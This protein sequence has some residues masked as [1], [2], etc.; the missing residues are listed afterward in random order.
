MKSILFSINTEFH[1]LVITSLIKQY[2]NDSSKYRVTIL[3]QVNSDGKRFKEQ[4][5]FNLLNANIIML[6]IDNEGV[7]Y[8]T[9]ICAAPEGTKPYIT[10][11]KGAYPSRIRATLINYKFL[12]LQR[13]W[14][15]RIN[16]VSNKN[17]FLKDTDE[18]WISYPEK[19]QNKTHKKVVEINLFSSIEQVEI[20]S[21]IF[22]FNKKKEMPDTEGVIFYLNQWYSE[23]KVYDY[24]IEMLEFILNKYPDKKIYIKLHPNTHNSQI[25]KFEKMPR[26]VLNRSTIPA[27]I[28]ILN[29]RNSIVFS[30]WSASLLINN[31]TCK[32]YWL[33]KL[34][35]V[36]KLIGWFSIINPTNHIKEIENINLLNY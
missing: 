29:L 34:P 4:L 7:K 2:Y 35:K 25:E 16:I 21:K 8:G 6:H 27:E 9:T 17:G 19:Y 26:I 24:E 11:S 15:N 13:L 30:L 12:L 14:I 5:N 33:N 36:I 22:N 20:A 32:F 18:V 23:F 3:V 31:D 28:F 10:I 1:V